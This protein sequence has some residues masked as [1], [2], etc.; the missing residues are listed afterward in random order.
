MKKDLILVVGASGTVGTEVVRLL[1]AEGHPVRSTTSQKPK[2]SASVQVNLA[3]GEGLQKAFEGVDKAFFLSPP[4]YTDQYQMLSPLIQEAKRRGLKK[5]VLMTAMGANA[6]EATPFRKA[7]IELEKSGLIYNIVRP[8][9]FLQNF[10]TFWVQ[11]IREQGKILLPAG[12]AKTSFIDAKDVSAVIA[13]LLL[14]NQFDNKAFDITGPQAVDHD[15]VAQEISSVTGKKVIYQEIPAT[16][17]KKGLLSAG[18][19]EDYSDFLLM[20]MGF[21]K[22]GYNAAVTTAVKD[23]LGRG[24][25]TL[26]QYAQD[27]KGAWL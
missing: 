27:T 1:K 9:W 19:P 23:I 22:E 7:E 4:G 10:S 24:P 21:L 12:Q 8:N 20:I 5:V 26:H 13:K 2:D 3:T 17:L 11:G 25:R 18:L 16:E 14:T 6:S 15:E